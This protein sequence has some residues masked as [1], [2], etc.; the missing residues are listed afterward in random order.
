MKEKELELATSL[1]EALAADFEP[2]KYNDD[3]RD[4]LLT[5][6]EAKKQGEEVVATP[7]PKAR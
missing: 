4:N 5:M 6:I 7:E 2:E 1:M 3:Y